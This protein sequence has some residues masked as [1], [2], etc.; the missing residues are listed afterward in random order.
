MSKRENQR[1]TG[2]PEEKNEHPVDRFYRLKREA[3]KREWD[4][5]QEMRAN[6]ATTEELSKQE[7]ISLQAGYCGD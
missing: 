5:L 4:K 6:G 7:A 1:K 2:E 3:F